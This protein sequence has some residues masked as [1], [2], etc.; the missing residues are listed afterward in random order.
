MSMSQKDKVML[1]VTVFVLLFGIVGM[2]FRSRMEI[3]KSMDKINKG[4]EE[5]LFIQKELINASDSW[6][7]RYES[8]KEKMPVFPPEEQ[9]DT[10]WLNIMDMVA[11]KYDFKIRSRNAKDETI[12]SGVYEFTIEVRDWES[13]LES[14]LKF[15]HA[16]QEEGAMLDV[17]DL[18]I[19]T[20]Q[21]KPG[22]LK[23]SFVLYCAYMRSKDPTRS[24]TL[25]KSRAVSDTSAT[26]PAPIVAET[27]PSPPVAEAQTIMP[28]PPTPTVA[29]IEIEPPAPTVVETPP[30]P[31]V[32]ETPTTT[33]TLI[34]NIE[35]SSE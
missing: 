4:L 2:Q 8:V 6:R 26:P 32:A 22:L 20:V 18:R 23:G 28:I 31:T 7:A 10:Y 11:E 30:A 21:N 12:L 19:S 15:L 5:T 35:E 34:P 33:D 25:D 13:T 16:M 27:P 3:I 29:N 17:R 9:V 1:T 24:A 14:L